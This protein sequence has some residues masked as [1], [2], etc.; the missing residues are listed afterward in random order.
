M[1]KHDLKVG[2]CSQKCDEIVKFF[3]RFDE[4][5]AMKSEIN[6]IFGELKREIQNLIVK[7]KLEMEKK[8]KFE[9]FKHEEKDIFIREEHIYSK[10]NK[11]IINFLKSV[12][13][14][15]RNISDEEQLEKFKDEIQIKIDKFKKIPLFNSEEK[16]NLLEKVQKEKLLFELSQLLDIQVDMEN[17]KMW[18]LLSKPSK[19]NGNSKWKQLKRQVAKSFKRPNQIQKTVYTAFKMGIHRAN[20][21]KIKDK[22]KALVIAKKDK[23]CPKSPVLESK[24][25]TFKIIGKIKRFDKFS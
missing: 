12:Y 23:L 1:K 7:S 24:G 18:D 16:K 14:P 17:R 25:L 8:E 2:E 3:D 15:I 19:G 13:Y 20:S 6:P 4:T 21:R 11:N 5:V 22:P 9:K 10:T